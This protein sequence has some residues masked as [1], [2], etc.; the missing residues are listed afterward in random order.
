MKKIWT[1]TLAMVAIAMMSC[2]EQNVP[3]VTNVLLE[4]TAS[5]WKAHTDT[6]GK[7]KYFSCSFSVPEITNDYNMVLAYVM[8]DNTA[9]QMLPYTRHYEDA[10]GN[11]WTTTVDYEFTVGKATF[12]VTNSDFFYQENEPSNMMFRLAVYPSEGILE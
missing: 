5:D 2:K 11:L 9:Q 12:F 7:N 1:I 8:L 10:D 6:D 3:E 4:A